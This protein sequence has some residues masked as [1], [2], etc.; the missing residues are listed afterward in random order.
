MRGEVWKRQE[1]QNKKQTN[2]QKTK[3]TTTKKKPTASDSEQKKRTCRQRNQ[4]QCVAKCGRG[5]RNTTAKINPK[6]TN[7]NCREQQ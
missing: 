1:K 3:T 6:Q 7:K 5:K 4:S 2:K